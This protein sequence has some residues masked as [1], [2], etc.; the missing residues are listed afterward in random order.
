[1]AAI[2][3]RAV[4]A[5]RGRHGMSHRGGLTALG[6]SNTG[7]LTSA[8]ALTWRHTATSLASSLHDADAGRGL[9]TTSYGDGGPGM[10]SNY[11]GSFASL[12][13]YT[14]SPR[15]LEVP[16]SHTQAHKPA[17]GDAAKHQHSQAAGMASKSRRTSLPR[18]V[19]HALQDLLKSSG[20]VQFAVN[21]DK[22]ERHANTV[23]FV[24]AALGV[25]LMIIDE[26]RAAA[27]A[28]GLAGCCSWC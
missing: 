10:G 15:T 5:A 20:H 11:S 17:S 2:A 18:R 9:N 27:G 16:G 28:L 24:L 6:S 7:F 26:V 14:S 3:R 19:Q 8:P 23:L 4:V 1:M 25:L 12:A 21:A 22:E 13:S